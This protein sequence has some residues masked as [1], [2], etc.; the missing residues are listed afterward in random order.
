MSTSR[1]SRKNITIGSIK[2]EHS[3]Y[4][5]SGPTELTK[6]DP[7]HYFS[8][9]PHQSKHDSTPIKDQDK[10]SSTSSH[11]QFSAAPLRNSGITPGSLTILP[12]QTYRYEGQG[13]SFQLLATMQSNAC[14]QSNCWQ[15]CNPMQ[16]KM[17][18][19]KQVMSLA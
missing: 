18:R 6:F 15:P 19:K 12:L 7:P 8:N 17:T 14:M 11:M 5:L 9:V 1:V 13:T 4:G 16:Q 2:H 3:G 10:Y